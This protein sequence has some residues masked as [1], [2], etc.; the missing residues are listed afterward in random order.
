MH[1][2]GLAIMPLSLRHDYR[3]HRAF[4]VATQE[5]MLSRSSVTSSQIAVLKHFRNR[6][7][8]PQLAHELSDC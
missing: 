3:S 4:A 5:M 2:C 8:R 6:E 7:L 1:L